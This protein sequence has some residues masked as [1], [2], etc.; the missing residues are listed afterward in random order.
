MGDASGAYGRFGHGPRSSRSVSGLPWGRF[1]TASGHPWRAKG[2]PRSALG[3][4][5]GAQKPSQAHPDASPMWPWAP[6]T[7]QDQ[8]FVNLGSIWDGFSAIFERFFVDFRSSR[9]RRRHKSRI[10]KRSR[11][12]LS[13]RLGSCVVQSLRTALTSFEMTFEHYMFSLFSLRTHKPT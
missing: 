6:K 4:H 12:I 9:V 1:W 3:R 5:L 8:F 10:S 7:A 2:A 11:V 13:A